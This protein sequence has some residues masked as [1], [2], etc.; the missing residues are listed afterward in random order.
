[1]LRLPEVRGHPVI[2]EAATD[3]IALG[4]AFGLAEPWQDRRFTGQVLALPR[5]RQESV[6]AGDGAVVFFDR[7]PACTPALSRY[8]GGGP[9]PLHAGEIDRAQSLSPRPHPGAGGLVRGPFKWQ[10]AKRDPG[11]EIGPVALPGL[12]CH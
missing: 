12:V 2:E 5:R 3:V 11:I 7:P 9:S 6:R 10:N 8:L 4:Q 1:M